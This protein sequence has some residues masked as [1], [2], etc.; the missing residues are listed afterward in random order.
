MVVETDFLYRS[1]TPNGMEKAATAVKYFQLKRFPSRA[2]CNVTNAITRTKPTGILTT[3]HYD[4]NHSSAI[5]HN[6]E[7]IEG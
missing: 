1:K 7:N 3:E 6:K 2:Y 4:K 5:K